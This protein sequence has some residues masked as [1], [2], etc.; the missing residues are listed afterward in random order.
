ME[1]SF[2]YD[3]IYR[4]AEKRYPCPN[5]LLSSVA[6]TKAKINAFIEGFQEAMK[7][8][9][10]KVDNN[11]NNNQSESNYGCSDWKWAIY[12]HEKY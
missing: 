1:K 12:C 5:S 7:L 4:M 3:D 10:I 8:G 6:F 11:D 2:T 9:A